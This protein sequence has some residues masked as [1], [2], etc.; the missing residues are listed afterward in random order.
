MQNGFKAVDNSGR[1]TPTRD[2]RIYP[3][4]CDAAPADAW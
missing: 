4:V 2:D 1:L 3:A